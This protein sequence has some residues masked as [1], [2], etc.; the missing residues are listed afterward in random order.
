MEGR[1]PG[2]GAWILRGQT[3]DEDQQVVVK[4]TF[5]TVVDRANTSDGSNSQTRGMQHSR[6]DSD[7]SS[8]SDTLGSSRPPSR[9]SSVRESSSGPDLE[10]Q[11]G[12]EGGAASRG[13]G[14]PPRAEGG[15]PAPQMDREQLRAV[16]LGSELHGTGR[17]RPCKYM[18]TPSGC[19]MKQDCDFCHVGHRR[20]RTRPAKST[21]A[22]CKEMVN[23]LQEAD[24]EGAEAIE[25][26]AGRSP[27]LRGL[28]KARYQQVQD[29]RHA[30]SSSAAG[31]RPGGPDPVSPQRSRPG[32]DPRQKMIQSL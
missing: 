18:G 1:A 7:L 15:P 10:D 9:T 14:R 19:A 30:S 20:A 12:G 11:S 4:N 31:G 13:R 25:D 22:K 23:N 32:A 28:L 24:T 21:R 8:Q 6:S 29:E 2:P 3:P 16:S 5:I 27:Y 26:L 17:C